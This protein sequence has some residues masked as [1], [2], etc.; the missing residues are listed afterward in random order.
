MAQAVYDWSVYGRYTL[1]GLTLIEKEF[2]ARVK[3]TLDEVY[4]SYMFLRKKN[5][6]LATEYN[7]LQERFKDLSNENQILVL[8]EKMVKMEND[9]LRLCLENDSIL[10]SENREVDRR[11]VEIEM[12]DLEHPHHVWTKSKAERERK[13]KAKERNSGKT[14]GIIQ[15]VEESTTEDP[16][17]KS[18]LKKTKDERSI[19]TQA[20]A[21]R[22]LRHK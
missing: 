14:E 11:D 15:Q 13:R 1:D 2:L 20:E 12:S 18:I 5:K 6:G 16:V 17:I 9:N 3:S 10:R 22:L 8:R 21:E 7:Q 4:M 19:L